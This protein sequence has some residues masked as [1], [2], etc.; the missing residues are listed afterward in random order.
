VKIL[1]FVAPRMRLNPLLS[2]FP[3]PAQPPKLSCVSGRDRVVR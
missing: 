1:S 3:L 2:N